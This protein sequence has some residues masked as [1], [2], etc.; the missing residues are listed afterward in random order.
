MARTE[1]VY[2]FGAYRLDASQHL[3]FRHDQLIALPPKATQ[4]L[5]ILIENHGRLVE[6]EDLMKGVWPDT[7]VEEA[8]LTLQISALRKVLQEESSNGSF[9]ETVPRRGYRFVAPVL[10]RPLDASLER[11]GPASRLSGPRSRN[12]NALLGVLIGVFCLATAVWIAFA[13]RHRNQ[14]STAIAAGDI[15]SLAVLPLQ[16]LSGDPAQEYLADGLTEELVT[17]LAQ[18]HGLRVISRT[19]SMRYKGTQNPL[20]EIARELGVDGI[21]EGSVSRSGERVRIHVQLIR[22]SE[23]VHIWA[24]TYEGDAHDI[25]GL[26]QGAA[27]AIAQ[28][29]RVRLSPEEEERLTTVRLINPAAHEAY[30]KGRYEFNQ[31]TPASTKKSVAYFKEATEKDPNYAAAY[32]ALGEA[33]VL[34]TANSIAAPRD[35]VPKAKQAAN[36]ALALDPGMGEAHATLGYLALFYDWDFDESGKQFR[37]AIELSPNYAIAHQW[38]GIL[39]ITEKRFDEAEHEFR[40][41]LGLD[42]LSL[43]TSADLA[44]VYFYSGRFDETIRQAQKILEINGSFPPA[45]DLIGMAY[46]QKGMYSAADAAYQKYVELG[47]GGD[48]RMHLAHL[49]AVTGR[50]AEAHKLLREM[51]N[52]PRGEFVSPYDIA[53]VYAGLGDKSH[54]LE[55]MDSAVQARAAMIPFSGIDPLLS[56]LRTDP[57]F[58]SLLHRIGLPQLPQPTDRAAPT[59]LTSNK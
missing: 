20:P 4:T 54:A 22:A 11:V 37:R 47:G 53:S 49:Y 5:V 56:P 13:V 55:W 41:A 9:I 2:E 8:N 27:Q 3:L 33:Y 16:N 39:L 40:I 21:V 51:E 46:E 29:I 10:E 23:D 18:L 35:S 1:K 17:D 30:L 15:H 25:L 6:K 43:M 19:S 32:V 28:A 24:S 58:Q 50:P 57:H 52:P 48:A 26:Q 7:F 12:R 14:Q 38:Y 44:Q 45:H 59:H 31:R 34:L 42:P 36:R